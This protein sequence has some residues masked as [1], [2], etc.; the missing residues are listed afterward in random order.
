MSQRRAPRS[1]LIGAATTAA[2]LAL[3]GAGSAPPASAAGSART[4]A[5]RGPAPAPVPIAGD[6]DVGPW[7]TSIPQ[8]TSAL[9]ALRSPTQTAT[10]TSDLTW[11]IRARLSSRGSV[12]QIGDY[13]SGQVVEVATGRILWAKNPTVARVPA[14]NEKL[15]TAFVALVSMGESTRFTT[16]VLQ[17]AAQPATVY[18]K[19]SG[20]PALS[21]SQLTAMASAVATKVKSQGRT[22]VAV[23]VDDSLFPAPTNATGWKAEWIPGTVAPV[24]ALVVDQVNV[25]DT[26]INAGQVFAAK[27]KAAGVTATSVA[28]GVA[29]AGA[30]TIASTSSPTVGQLVQ[31]MLNASQNDYAEGLHRL[32]ALRRGHNADWAGARANALEVLASRGIDSTSL[33]INDGSGL[34]QTGR[35]TPL[36]AIDVLSTIRM[37][38]ALNSVVFA[39][40]AL[41]TAGVSGTLADRFDTAPTNCARSI[42]RAKTGTLATATALSGVASGVDGR[43]R[44][45]SVIINGV[46]STAESRADVDAL[47]ATATGC[48]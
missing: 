10:S 28:R 37:T 44:I 46:T 41:P 48:Y 22:S 18:L 19:G 30:A 9:S 26:S 17:V 4:A 34:S 14:S 23:V 47:A 11:T 25:V 29:P 24:R 13:A 32:S 39:A 42:V 20:D 40:A 33:V 35:L 3:F 36:T 7:T 16:P 43:E 5:V 15:V 8:V 2:A 38:P 21:S 45:F 27:L 6:S 1:A 31:T 12:A